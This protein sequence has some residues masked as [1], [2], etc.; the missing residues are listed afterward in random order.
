MDQANKMP[1]LRIFTYF[2]AKT[3][4]ETSVLGREKTETAPEFILLRNFLRYTKWR[5]FDW[6]NVRHVALLDING[7]NSTKMAKNEVY[8][9]QPKVPVLRI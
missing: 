2:S 7:K 3:N 6:K 8:I 4:T 9:R 1:I 5:I